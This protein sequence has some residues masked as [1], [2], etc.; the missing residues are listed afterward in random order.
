MSVKLHFVAPGHSP[1]GILVFVPQEKV[2]FTGDNL[3]SQFHAYVGT[4]D[5]EGW[6]KNLDFL[7][8]LDVEFIIPGF[9]PSLFMPY[10]RFHV[11]KRRI[12]YLFRPPSRC[13][14]IR[15]KK[16]ANLPRF[17]TKSALFAM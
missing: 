10:G 12:V 11:S 13:C 1:G 16:A 17:L 2:V 4:A 8:G 14:R 5:M 9:L 15:Q 3:F 7:M 6:Q